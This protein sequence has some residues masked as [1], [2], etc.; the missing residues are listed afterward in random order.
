MPVMHL[1]IQFV[2]P[3]IS[4]EQWDPAHTVAVCVQSL[5]EGQLHLCS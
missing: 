2:M 5:R 4:A 3:G 1:L